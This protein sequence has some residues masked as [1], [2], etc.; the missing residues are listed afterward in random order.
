MK[1]GV[2]QKCVK[3]KKTFRQWMN[4]DA[5]VKLA[6]L[7]LAVIVG[8]VSAVAMAAGAWALMRK[9]VS[10]H[11]KQIVAQQILIQD[12]DVRV[13]ELEKFEAEQMI[14]NAMIR[15]VDV[16]VTAVERFQAEQTIHNEWMRGTLT[17]IESKLPGG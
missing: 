12:S 2:P 6:K 8:L 11:D 7:G 14:H 17:R 15:S 4:G 10:D 5:G 9:E 16:R 3:P 13:T 1:D